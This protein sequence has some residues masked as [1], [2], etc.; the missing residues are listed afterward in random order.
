MIIRDV[1]AHERLDQV[2]RGF[3]ANISHELKTPIGA[4][5]LLAETLE[6]ETDPEIVE[7]LSGRVLTEAH[8]AAN[9]VED[10]LE[11]SRVEVGE[12][13]DQSPLSVQ[14]LVDEATDLVRSAAEDRRFAS[15]WRSTANSWCAATGVSWCRHWSTC[16]TTPSAT[17]TAAAES[18]CGPASRA[19]TPRSR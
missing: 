5:T 16:S 17:P 1:S 6:G 15:T 13:H 18:P 10:L 9:I 3:V 2:R 14:D 7:R 8:R 19:R 11:L 4:L 12:A